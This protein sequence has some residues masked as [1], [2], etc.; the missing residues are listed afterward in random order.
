MIQQSELENGFEP[1]FTN[2]C[3]LTLDDSNKCCALPLGEE[4]MCV[5]AVEMFIILG[6]TRAATTLRTRKGVQR[7]N[8]QILDIIHLISS[9]V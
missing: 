6:G 8:H 2:T 7:E 3:R 9:S 5:V 1:L 4:A